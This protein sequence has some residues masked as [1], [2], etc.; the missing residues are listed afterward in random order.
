MVDLAVDAAELFLIQPLTALFSFMHSNL[1]HYEE[2]RR[3]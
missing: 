3:I 2:K 1:R